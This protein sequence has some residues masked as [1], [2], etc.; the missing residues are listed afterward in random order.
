MKNFGVDEVRAIIK[1]I[2]N[3]DEKKS[4]YMIIGALAVAAVGALGIAAY[5]VKKHCCTCEDYDY[6]DQWDNEEEYDKTEDKNQEE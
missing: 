2:K 3:T 5:V 1:D 6:F 4:V